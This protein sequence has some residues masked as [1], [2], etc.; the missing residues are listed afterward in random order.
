[1][2]KIF[3]LIFIFILSDVLIAQRPSNIPN[4]KKVKIIGNVVD[5]ETNQPLEY[6]TITLKNNRFPER[7]QG[8]ITNETGKFNLE[9]FPGKYDVLIEYI[10]FNPVK[11]EGELIR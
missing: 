5:Q 11:Y 4:I 10:G 3:S 1:M 9:I 2:K 6:A 7:I 8:G